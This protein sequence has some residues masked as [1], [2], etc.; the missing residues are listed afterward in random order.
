MHIYNQYDKKTVIIHQRRTLRGLTANVQGGRA[1]LPC[2]PGGIRIL[3]RPVLSACS[4][5][6]KRGWRDSATTEK[7]LNLLS[8]LHAAMQSK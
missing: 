4:H 1:S 3:V 8:E 7:D 6:R 2:R 5:W